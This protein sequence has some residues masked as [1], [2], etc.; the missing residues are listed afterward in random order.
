[1]IFQLFQAVSLV[2]TDVNFKVEVQLDRLSIC[3]LGR[4]AGAKDG[5]IEQAGKADWRDK[6]T[7]LMD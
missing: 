6:V 7:A 2:L 5:E 3:K 1:M 4:Q